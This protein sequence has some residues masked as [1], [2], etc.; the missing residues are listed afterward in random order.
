MSTR[1][2]VQD[3]P[4]CPKCGTTLEM[5]TCDEVPELDYNFFDYTKNVMGVCPDCGTRYRWTEIWDYKGVT[6]IEE[7]PASW[8]DDDE[9]DREPFPRQTMGGADMM[10]LN[11]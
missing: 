9:D 3:E 10:A 4:L 6:D 7:R 11:P 8:M 2:N 5:L 1:N